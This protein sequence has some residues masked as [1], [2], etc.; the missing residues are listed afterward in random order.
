[1]TDLSFAEFGIAEPH[2]RIITTES[3]TRPPSIP[4]P[5]KDHDLLGLAL[6]G[7]VKPAA[8]ALPLLQSLCVGHKPHKPKFAGAGAGPTGLQP[9]QP[10]DPRDRRGDAGDTRPKILEMRSLLRPRKGAR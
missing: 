2:R 9:A 5:F 1:M 8:F 10:A 4:A 6:T 7:T 3:H